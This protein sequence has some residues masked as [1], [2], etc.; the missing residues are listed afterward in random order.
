VVPRRAGM[1]GSQMFAPL[2]SGLESYIEEK[3][4]KNDSGAEGG[5]RPRRSPF[6]I[7]VLDF[8]LLRG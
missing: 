2:N 5:V 4:R 1:E 7:L 3:K 6:A 8:V